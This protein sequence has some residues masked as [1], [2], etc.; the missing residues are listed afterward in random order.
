MTDPQ[1]ADPAPLPSLP[2]GRLQG[3]QVFL[4][5][6]RQAFAAAAEQGW[7]HITLS[8]PDF[9][10]WPLGER[11]VVDALNRWAHRGRTLKMLARNYDQLRLLHPRFVQWRVT[12]SHLIE[13]HACHGAAGA[14]LPSAITSPVW[15]L[16]RLDPLRN[17][18]VASVDAERRV[19][20]RER[21]NEC[22]LRSTPAFPA[23]QL[24]L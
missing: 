14:E 23:S 8:D 11:V 3:R 13:A 7:N 10:D 22:W 5:T 18:L 9:A 16:E 12:W 24:G 17:T 19:A 20:L 6:V 4:D 1:A 21:V 2:T 15:T